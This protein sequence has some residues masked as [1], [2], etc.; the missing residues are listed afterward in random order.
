MKKH[1]FTYIFVLAGVFSAFALLLPVVGFWKAIG[2]EAPHGYLYQG[3][4]FLG[5]LLLLQ[6]TVFEPYIRTADER[7]AQT[8]G[9]RK[10]AEKDELLSQEKWDMYQQRIEEAKIK[11]TQTRE[12]LALAAEEEEKKSL[13][14]TREKSSQ[15]LEKEKEKI[16]SQ[17]KDAQSGLSSHRDELAQ[18]IVEKVL[19]Q[20]DAKQRPRAQSQTQATRAS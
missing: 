5:L 4:L 18:S 6:M 14:A 3:L 13:E 19:G 8:L 7:D 12:A 9:K 1:S 10:L 16:A 20:V 11:A 17:E 15:W 2:V